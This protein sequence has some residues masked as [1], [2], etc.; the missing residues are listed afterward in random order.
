MGGVWRRPRYGVGGLNWHHWRCFE[1]VAS[2]FVHGRGVVVAPTTAVSAHVSPLSTAVLGLM[3][4]MR[5]GVHAGVYVDCVGMGQEVPD[6]EP[7]LST[8]V[9]TN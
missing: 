9:L 6:A 7:D 8:T 3:R 4:L 2:I 1:V 5:V